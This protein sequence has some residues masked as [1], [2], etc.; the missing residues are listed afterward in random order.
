M[1][2][3]LPQNNILNKRVCYVFLVKFKERGVSLI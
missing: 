3:L 2:L 1:G